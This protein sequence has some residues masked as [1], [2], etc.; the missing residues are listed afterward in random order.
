MLRALAGTVA[1]LLAC[2]ACGAA[3]PGA[4]APSPR[5]KEVRVDGLDPCALLTPAQRTSLQLDQPPYRATS[6]SPF[7]G[8]QVEQCSI[9]GLSPSTSL[10]ITLV[11]STGIERF[12]DRRLQIRTDA[13]TTAGF[14]ALTVYPP[15]PQHYCVAVV[16]ASPGQLI[17]FHYTDVGQKPQL[18]QHQL[19]EFVLRA[20]GEAMTSLADR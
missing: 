7:Y 5:P 12:E 2:T 18:P 10:L 6:Q 3:E 11:A 9:S 14:R 4:T 15:V 13:A 19:C 16:D 20:A 1:I 17:E 8:D